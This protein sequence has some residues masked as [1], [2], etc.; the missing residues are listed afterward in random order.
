GRLMREALRQ[1][2]LKVDLVVPVPMAARRRK[3]R[4]YNQAALLAAQVF[5]AVGG[6]VA[7]C[8]ERDERPAQMGL[9][10]ELRAMN[11]AGAV[12]SRGQLHGERVLLIDDVATTGATLS[13]CAE[14]IKAAGAGNV[15]ALVFARDL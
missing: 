11:L 4:G 9:S 3:E 10:A 13:A 5:E 7:D 1:R 14:A 2:P 6:T 15:S 8:L 12:R